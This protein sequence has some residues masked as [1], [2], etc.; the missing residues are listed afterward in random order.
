MIRRSPPKAP[1]D[2]LAQTGHVGCHSIVT[3]G[4]AQ[5]NPK[6]GH[7]LVEDQHAPVLV[8]DLA[9][10]LQEALD[11]GN[12]VHVAG[13][14]LDDDGGDLGAL[15]GEQLPDL[16]RIVVVQGNRVLGQGR[17]HTR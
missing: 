13:H 4:P 8:A 2:D 3:L 11:G 17:R 1:A 10:P 7:H 14:R 12:T 5:G 9:Q 15:S 6:P 16:G